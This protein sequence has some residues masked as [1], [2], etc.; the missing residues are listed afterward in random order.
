[1]SKVAIF[2]NSAEENLI[3]Q[4]I[5]A[6]EKATTGEVHVHLSSGRIHKSIMDDAAYVFRQ[7]GLDRTRQRNG[8]LLYIAVSAH[9][10]AI[11]GDEGIH[12]IVGQAGWDAAAAKLTAAFAKGDF[13]PGLLAAIDDIGAVLTKHF[14]AAADAHNPDELPNRPSRS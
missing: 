2:L 5:G 10:F 11:L 12:R 4:R 7:L 1:M 8:V 3:A 13:G 9:E 6:V 14:P